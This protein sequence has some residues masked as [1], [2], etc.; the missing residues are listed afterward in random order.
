MSSRRSRSSRSWPSN[1][2]PLAVEGERDGGVAGSGGD[3]LG[4]APAAIQKPHEG[5]L[6]LLCHSET[7]TPPENAES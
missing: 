6:S 3:L 4:E 1:R 2:P 7:S 5:M